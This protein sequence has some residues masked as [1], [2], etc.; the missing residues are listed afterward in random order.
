[1]ITAGLTMRETLVWP[2]TIV[3]DPAKS[4]ERY[5]TIF[6]NTH[7]H[8]AFSDATQPGNDPQK[9]IDANYRHLDGLFLT[10]H[11]EHLNNA[12][13][14]KELE[15][16]TANTRGSKL[17]LRAEEVTGTDELN[18]R[19]SKDPAY[20]H[21][22]GHVVVVN[23]DSFVGRR[24]F[25]NGQP[26]K[27]VDTFQAFLA[28]L[29]T[30]PNGMGIF[31]HPSLYMTEESF[32]GFAAPPNDPA[33][34]QM[35]GCELSSHGLTYAGLGNGKELRSS[36]E[37]CYRELLRKGWRVG[38]YMGGDEHIPP[39]GTTNAVTGMYVA[40]RTQRGILEAM[41]ARR[42]FATEEPGSL[43]ALI[44]Q[45]D[46]GT[47]IIGETLTTTQGD[48]I[49]HVRCRSKNAGVDLL[50]LVFLSTKDAFYDIEIKSQQFSGK[51]E[52]WGTVVSNN[53]LEQKNIF[54]VYAKARLRN[55]RNL[56]SSPIWLQTR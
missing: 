20:Q 54:A 22:W 19:S 9:I 37:A 52:H 32:E 42:T 51:D 29:A 5:Q 7:T 18:Q 31:A 6:I 43:I 23:T 34:K 53:D 13:W 17:C 10:D 46:I 26:P 24:S 55:G 48:N 12:E 40:E 41:A 49:F 39:Y 21:G 50:S 36:N 15:L 35:V 14:L 44:G 3:A 8:T 56:L 16:A 2:Q 47:A 28:W 1:M 30:N 27:L 45:S 4:Y 11:G 38:A 33:I 25:G